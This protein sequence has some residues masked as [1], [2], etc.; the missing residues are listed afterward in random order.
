MNENLKIVVKYYVASVISVIVFLFA[1]RT[2]NYFDGNIIDMLRY[3]DFKLDLVLIR[4]LIL[5]SF[6]FFQFYFFLLFIIFK[7]KY[8]GRVFQLLYSIVVAGEIYFFY[9]QGGHTAWNIGINDIMLENII[10]AFENPDFITASANQ[11][12]NM[13]FVKYFV[14]PLVLIFTY[15]EIVKAFLPKFELKFP[16]IN[17]YSWA[18]PLIAFVMF[19][20]GLLYFTSKT[21]TPYFLRPL[22]MLEER[23][24]NDLKLSLFPDKFKRKNVYITPKL[25][26]KYRNIIFVM[27]ESIRGD[28]TSLN[29]PNMKTTPFLMKL[30][31][32]GVFYNLGNLV[33]VGNCSF[34]SNEFV[35]TGSEDNNK[36]YLKP[37]IYQYM[38]KAGYQTIRIDSPQK[39]YFNGVLPT[40]KK[41]IDKYISEVSVYPE[42]KRDF[43]ALKEIEKILKEKGKHFI[44]FTKQGAHFP[45]NKS[46]PNGSKIPKSK[47]KE[48]Y[49]NS[50]KYNVNYFWE[51]LSKIVDRNDTIV[52]WVGDHGVDIAPDKGDKDIKV[53]HC[54]E[55]LDHFKELYNVSGG[56]YSKKRLP[57]LFINK[58]D[59]QVKIFSTMLAV[60]GYKE[61]DIEKYYPKSFFVEDNVSLIP[62]YNIGKHKFFNFNIKKDCVETDEG[63]KFDTKG[64]GD[65]KFYMDK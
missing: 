37:T 41:Y 33:S 20:T 57:K 48:N 50:I 62:I 49:M 36:T 8:I 22:Y 52:F 43:V 31:K 3:Y 11:Y 40:D 24:I 5:K 54:E 58:R 42:Y 26:S 56:I 65:N 46:Y 59:K 6:I 53:T 28:F 14:I 21:N 32:K 39:G 38:K 19:T 17:I 18:Y 34:T 63:C 7:T 30:M 25:K 4:E 44:Y 47:F 60:A 9:L 29:N 12:M 15:F 55:G 27:D 61:A 35:F 1:H 2:C 23:L 45:F 13:F 16:D 10:M 51:K 64:Y